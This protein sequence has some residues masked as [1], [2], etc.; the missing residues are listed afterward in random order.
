[1]EPY[2]IA[3]SVLCV[4]AQRL[5]RV[6]C[7]ECRGRPFR[8]LR[9]WRG[10]LDGPDV[11]KAFRGRGCPACKGTGYRGRTVSYEMLPPMTD[12]RGG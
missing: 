11:P 5:V 8:R 1:M 6:I 9:R 3:S 12:A 4:I 2:L 7:A 10:D